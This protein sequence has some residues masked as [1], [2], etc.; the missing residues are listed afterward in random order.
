MNRSIMFV[1]SLGLAACSTTT[2]FAPPD[3]Q[4]RSR[5]TDTSVARDCAPVPANPREQINRDVN[6]ALSLT[7]NF[8]IGYRC[9]ARAAADGRQPWE[10]LSFLSLVGSGLATALGAGSDVAII[11]GAGNAVFTAG[12]AYYAPREQAE[13]LN[14]AVDALLCIQTES[15]GISAFTLQAAAQTERTTLASVLRVNTSSIGVTVETQY[16]NMVA[17]A[18]MSVE[19]VAAQRLSARGTFDAAGVAAE[20]ERIARERREAEDRRDNPPDTS[21]FSIYG[22]NTRSAVS[23]VQDV[24]LDLNVLRP[25]LEQ[26]ATRAKV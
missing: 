26:C 22:D 11:G 5:L 1:A 25:K 6:G 18:L 10:L 7:D 24:Q 3:I 9:A 14:D 15:T 12:R 20:I 21:S 19:R 2:S 17:A 23:L 16:F 13:I 8:I 4:I